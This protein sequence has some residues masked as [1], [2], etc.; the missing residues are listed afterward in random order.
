MNEIPHASFK[1]WPSSSKLSELIQAE[2]A[3]D[4]AT[5]AIIHDELVDFILWCKELFGED[6]Y[7]ECAPGCSHEQIEVN[8]RLK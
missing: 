6:F 8:K 1:I 5:A 2:K 7:I 3:G 4:E